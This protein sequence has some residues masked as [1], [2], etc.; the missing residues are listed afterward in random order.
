[1]PPWLTQLWYN[2]VKVA[3]FAAYTGLLSERFVGGRNIP[4]A[5]PVIIVANHQSFIDPFFLG[6]A[7]P[8]PITYLTRETLHKNRFLSWFMSSLGSIPIDHRGFS[9]DGLQA[10]LAALA[11]GQCLGVFPE[12][13]RSPDGKLA[14]FKLG[15]SL[16]IKKSKATIVPAGIAGG[17]GFWPR[18]R[19]LPRLS[20]L[21]L[22]A[23]DA[24][25]GVSFGTP[26]DPARFANMSR[27]EMMAG[28]RL[29]VQAE[30]VKA[31]GIRRK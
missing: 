23:T 15:A 2:S 26:I 1:M 10:S 11:S 27:E 8:R 18:T 20:P 24:A 3:M 21:F 5:G 30:M 4:K 13:T 14:E 7:S 29:A 16:L 19:K 22:R 31:E 28:L 25:I 12:G 17:F 6:V 9:R